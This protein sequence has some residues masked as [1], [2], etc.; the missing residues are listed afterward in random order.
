MGGSE[1]ISKCVDSIQFERQMRKLR[2]NIAKRALAFSGNVAI[3]LYSVTNLFEVEL[4]NIICI[5]KGLDII[6][7]HLTLNPC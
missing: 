3:S 7:V 6:R 2:F 5:V 1:D 4:N